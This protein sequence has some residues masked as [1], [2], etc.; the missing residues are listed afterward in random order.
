MKI[1]EGIFATSAEIG[2]AQLKFNEETGLIEEFGQLNIPRDQVDFYYN[3]DHLIFAG[4]GDVHIHAREDVSGKQNYK[5]DFITASKAAINGG[6]T[7]FCDMPNNPTPPVNDSSYEAKLKL[8]HKALVPILLYAGIGPG[9]KPLTNFVPYKAYMGP[10]VGSLFFKDDQELE[11]TIK[12]YSGENVSFHC[13]DPEVLESHKKETT[14]LARRP[15]EAE[16]LATDT[17]LMLIEKYNL[18]GKLCHYSAG[19]GLSKIMVAK[20]KGVN[21]VCEVTPQHLYFNDGNIPDER[22]TYFQM[23]PPIRSKK[24]QETMLKAFLKGEIDFLATDHAPHTL[25]EKGM[26]TSGLTGL[27]TYGAFVTWLLKEKGMD[28]KLVSLTCCEN[29]GNFV[30]MFLPTLKKIDS[31]FEQ[32]GNGFG[33]LTKGFFAN[34]TVL[35]LQTPTT[36]DKNDLQTKVGHSPFEGISFP[37]KV[38]DVFIGGQLKK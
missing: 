27:D 8:T 28:A 34:L 10:S 36:I 7:H 22:R 29:P 4:M 14:H 15:L 16:L 38:A 11:E 1:V 35:N 20:Q 31:F 21:V 30:N 9:T 24:D 26:G 32:F 3:D 25:E 2:R 13:E 12:D 6:L 5:E 19:E 17:A 18:K 23:N 37:G 33:H